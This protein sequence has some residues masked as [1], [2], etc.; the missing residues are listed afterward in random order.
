M[1]GSARRPGRPGERDAARRRQR[2]LPPRR[3]QAHSA[4]ASS[5]MA[6]P[7]GPQVAEYLVPDEYDVGNGVISIRLGRAANAACCYTPE[8]RRSRSWSSVSRSGS[9]SPS[10][11]RLLTSSTVRARSWLMGASAPT[12]ASSRSTRTV[13]RAGG[14]RDVDRMRRATPAS[15]TWTTSACS[16]NACSCTTRTSTSHG[17]DVVEDGP[18]ATHPRRRC[19]MCVVRALGNTTASSCSGTNATGSSR[20]R[21]MRH[22]LEPWCSSLTTFALLLDT[23]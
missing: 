9:R 8:A 21:R 19:V 15:R 3:P 17:A 13:R 16:M 4:P 2:G 6:A 11:V 12:V 18:I 20:S 5:A 1:T 14:D 10:L 7:N 23:L 22:C